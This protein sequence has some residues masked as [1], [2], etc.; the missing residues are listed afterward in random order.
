MKGEI[1]AK[2][3]KERSRSAAGG[4]LWICGPLYISLRNGVA[5][6]VNWSKESIS[7]TKFALSLSPLTTF[8]STS[9]ICRSAKRSQSE[10]ED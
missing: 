6:E 2:C 4:R 8:T 3:E 5:I 9:S 10:K 1:E 7:P